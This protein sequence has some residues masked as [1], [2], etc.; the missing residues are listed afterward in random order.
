M[1]LGSELDTLS[2]V[3][4]TTLHICRPLLQK[5]ERYWIPDK[6]VECKIGRLTPGNSQTYNRPLTLLFHSPAVD[7][8]HSMVMINVLFAPHSD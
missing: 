6:Q 4:I 2:V 5:V 3:I 8:M 7:T 1:N